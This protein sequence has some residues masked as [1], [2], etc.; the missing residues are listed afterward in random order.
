MRWTKSEEKMP[1]QSQWVVISWAGVFKCGQFDGRHP[2]GPAVV[3]HKLGKYWNGF[4]HWSPLNQP[5][6]K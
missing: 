5:K 6:T 2:F 1:K 4:D 3:D